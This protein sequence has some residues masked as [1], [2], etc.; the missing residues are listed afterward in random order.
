[1]KFPGR[2][3]P[4]FPGRLRRARTNAAEPGDG[5]GVAV[6]LGDINGDGRA[7][8]AVGTYGETTGDQSRAGAV[9]ILYGSTKGLRTSA[10]QGFTRATAGVP[11]VLRRAEQFGAAVALT[12]ANGDGLADLFVGAHDADTVHD[13][14]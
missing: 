6:C 10:A 1:M 5:F 8:L 11:G 2:A 3:G 9:T 13:G 4:S 12:Y 14:R 7:D